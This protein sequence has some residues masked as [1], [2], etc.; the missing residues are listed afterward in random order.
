[1]NS[2]VLK[3]LPAALALALACGAA[4]AGDHETEGFHGYF[5]AGA[6]SS[7]A[8][9]P[10]SCFGLGGNTQSYRLGNE[11]DSY[12][13]FGYTKEIAKAPNGAS[14]VA[15][16]WADAYKNGSDFGDAKLGIAKAY[17]EA[18]NLPFMNGGIVWMGKRHYYRPDIHMLD[19]Q[20][21]NMNGTGGGID[22]LPMG[23]GKFSYAIFKDNDLNNV[24][25]ATG[26]I[27]SG[28]ALR[29]NVVYEG[30]PVNPD[31][32]LDFAVSLISA[33]SKDNSE[34][35]HGGWQTSV[36]HRQSKVL[37]GGNTVG[38][39]YGVGPG[40]GLNGPCCARMGPSGSTLLGSDYTRVRVFDDLV[41]QPTRDFS[42]EF[43]A[44][45]QRDKSDKAGTSTWTTIGTR[46]VYALA[47]N[48][49]LQAELGVT[50][51][52]NDGAPDTM[53]LTKLTIAPTITL[54]R[55]YW[56]RPELRA[57]VSYGKWND[58]A[59]KAVNAANNQGPVY[60]SNT[61]GTSVG[62]QLE[63]WW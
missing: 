28:S 53:R 11:C 49:K 6:G 12:A 18:K 27:T 47:E 60:G 45:W 14:F 36:F 31:G 39:Q 30:L 40:T 8:K 38:L 43:V 34:Q 15:T 3:T 35:T 44:L 55:D 50:R 25:P 4:T 26:K 58:A 7:S 29:Q 48:F 21:I 59:T 46:P 1:M 16:I 5:R 51:V 42:M 54:G 24:D 10:Q 61:S 63:A 33:S 19:M 41:I 56:A 23:A 32:A 20:Y 62:L 2:T 37:G 13:E 52:K 22:A 9:G 17:V 57:F